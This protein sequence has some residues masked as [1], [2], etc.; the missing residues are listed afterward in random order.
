MEKQGSLS[1]VR[2]APGNG[3]R[4]L[5]FP[6]PFQG[7]LN[8]MLQVAH[9]LYTKGFSITIIH[10]VFNSPHACNY[11]H[12]TFKSIDD[13]LSVYKKNPDLDVVGSLISFLNESCMEPFRDCLAS[14]LAE[15]GGC[16]E[17]TI[18][19]LIA[20]AVWSFPQAVADSCKLPRIVLKTTSISSFLAFCA[21]P[22]F[23][24][25]G[26]FNQDSLSEA[27]VPEFPA[28]KL[29]DI[30]NITT[31]PE[32]LSGFMSG[33]Q[34]DIKAASAIIWNTFR[35][36]EEPEFATIC[37]EFSTPSFPIGPFHKYLPASSS[38]LLEQDR[39]FMSWLDLQAPNSV[40]YISFGSIA[41]MKEGEFK[42]IAQGLANS[43]Q[44]FLWVV[45]PGSIND[46][47][48]LEL[49]PDGFLDQ[50]IGRGHIIKWAPQQEVLAHPAIGS[51]WTHNG[52]NSTLESICEGVPMICSPT[53]ADQ[54]IASRYVNDVWGIGVYLENGLESG[55]IKRAIER[56]M[57]DEE[58]KEIRER[59][60]RLKEKANICLKQ[61]GSSYQSLESL[62]DYILS[63]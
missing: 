18:V 32:A 51:F 26:Y 1:S 39:S 33:V 61:C 14:L 22:L 7:H 16:A 13:G 53:F 40:I 23:L 34:A 4:L 60:T 38:S 27:P 56:V 9:I 8:P 36:L 30:P 45:R 48:W 11:P 50:V 57:V 19:C 20:D 24:K 17:E 41:K 62:V 42:E 21:T 46:S 10:T 47:E 44:P 58:G 59:M 63:F 54:P 3:R 43:K 52:W 15:G 29:K 12:F 55:E 25:K 49:L 28:L 35:E 5:L 37:Q 6:L 2:Q 31:C